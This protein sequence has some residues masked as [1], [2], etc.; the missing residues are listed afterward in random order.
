LS[1]PPGYLAELPPL[2]SEIS[3]GR[4]TVKANAVPLAGVEQA[5]TRQEA[6]G[7]RTVLIP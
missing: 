3:A 4:I 2:V 6:S 1:A 5:W 7:E